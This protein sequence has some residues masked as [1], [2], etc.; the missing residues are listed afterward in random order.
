MWRPL[1]VSTPC[2]RDETPELPFFGAL[3]VSLSMY[4]H[5]KY[6]MYFLNYTLGY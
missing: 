4:K 6:I 1:E 2:C 5:L 3:S